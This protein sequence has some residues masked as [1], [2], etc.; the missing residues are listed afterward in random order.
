VWPDAEGAV[1]V[2]TLADAF[3]GTAAL[4]PAG[5]ARLAL[6]LGGRRAAIE[7]TSLGDI[8]DRRHRRRLRDA[9]VAAADEDGVLQGV[10]DAR[11][12]DL[13]PGAA[14]VPDGQIG[15]HECHLRLFNLLADQQVRRWSTLL[16]LRVGDVRAW[17]QADDHATAE[18]IGL[19]FDRSLAG[20]AS[21]SHD[22]A[23][24]GAAV[25]LAVLLDHEQHAPSQ[26]LLDALAELSGDGHPDNV[27]RA[28]ARLVRTVRHTSGHQEALSGILAAAGDPRD[29]EIF[30]LR[31]LRLRRRPTLEE[32]ARRVGLSA[33]R[34]RQI[35]VRAEGRVRAAALA[36]PEDTRALIAAIRGWLGTVVPVEVADDLA[37]RLGA[38]SA[39]TRIGGLLLWLAGPYQPVPGRDGWL[40]H[41]PAVMVAR[42]AEWLA[43]DG[44]VRP[45]QEVRDE[46][47]VEGVRAEHHD[48][49]VAAC[50]GVA[51]DDMVVHG[52]GGV[53]TVAE[54]TLFATGRGLTPDEIAALVV[55]PDRADDLR[56][57]L[58]RDRRF[59]RVSAD[60]YELAEWRSAA[61]PASPASPGAT[62]AAGPS[63]DGRWWLRVPVDA[64]V[65][66][67]NL[68]LSDELLGVA[69][70]RPDHRRTFTSRYGPVTIIDEGP[71]P[72]LGP[73]RHVALA[74]GA[75]PGDEL[76]LGFG[77]AGDV[78]IRRR[79]ADHPRQIADER[80]V[81]DTQPDSLTAQGAS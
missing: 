17:A 76:W 59:V 42:T 54:R 55:G 48:A 58:E 47:A 10:A 23:R 81:T 31:T 25:D 79:D 50:G 19:A 69:S 29:L 45:A 67:G 15:A 46:L 63:L 49:W 33:E 75:Q 71:S 2:L 11:L 66:G 22:A 24:A 39:H 12:A 51:V 14:L 73:L 27:R 74:C 44:G 62:T 36:A 80:A 61:A 65:L 21:A 8:L 52:A 60:V 40:A 20:L 37:R 4:G 72:G 70:V 68:P 34:V 30:E 32:V 56:V 57:V 18:V 41:D 9:V 38:G 28:A 43:E 6:V 7:Q 64:G 77:P 78:S 5:R 1:S 3:T 35:R 16:G 13:A 26:P 53:A